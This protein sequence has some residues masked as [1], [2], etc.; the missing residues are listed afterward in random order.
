MSLYD[1][2]SKSSTVLNANDCDLSLQGL[3]EKALL[4]GLED[5]ESFYRGFVTRN[6]ALIRVVR[7]WFDN[8][9]SSELERAK[10][11][12]DQTSYEKA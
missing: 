6:V 11:G 2:Y 3:S 7:S 1:S 4:V 10:A 9:F 12:G 8:R 5:S